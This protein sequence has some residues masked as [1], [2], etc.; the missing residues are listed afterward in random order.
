MADPR[1]FRQLLIDMVREEF[2]PAA[3]TGVV[4]AV[5]TSGPGRLLDITLQPEG[6]QVQAKQAEMASGPATGFYFPVAVGDEVLV[7]FPLGDRNAGIAIAGIRNAQRPS[8]SAD[9]NSQPGVTHPNGFEVRGTGVLD[10]EGV[11]KRALIE[12]IQ[13]QQ[14]AMTA[15]MTALATSTNPAT[16]DVTA[17]AV[18]YQT[19]M[20]S[21]GYLARLAASLTLG[22]PYVSTLLT[23]E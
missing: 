13:A 18:A 11:L 2:A 22:P 4:T 17:A 10:P 9:D 23:T 16:A 5:D 14:N 1:D 21:N 8:P 20:A 19:A 6:A 7:V 12:G 15:F 3:S